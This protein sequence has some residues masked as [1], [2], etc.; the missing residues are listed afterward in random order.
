MTVIVGK[1][2]QEFFHNE[3]SGAAHA[4]GLTTDEDC[5]FYVV[6]LLCSFSR[7]D[8]SP[9]PG[10]E[11]LVFIYKRALEAPL[12]ERIP[13][14]KALGDSALYVAGFFADF[15]ERSLVGADYYISM[16]QNAY[17]SVADLLAAQHRVKGFA[18]VY[19][20]LAECFG[21][22]VGVLNE[23]RERGE[24][25]QTTDEDLLRLYDRWAR[26]KSPRL[27]RLLCRQGFLPL[28]SGVGELMQ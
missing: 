4:L 17:D 1:N 6:N 24:E 16:G 28:D 26:T 13:H 14:L 12:H 21:V 8:R 20:V 23:V 7:S 18:D 10:D 5:E 19:R 11:P 27:E 3:V 25:K 22:W 2:L 9:A 15:V